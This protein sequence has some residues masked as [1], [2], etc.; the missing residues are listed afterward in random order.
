MTA[1]SIAE[2]LGGKRSGRDSYMVRCPAHEDRNPSLSIAGQDGKL[3]VKCF[4]GCSQR[5]VVDALRARGLW[6][7]VAAP[8][9]FQKPPKAQ[10]GPIIN[11]YL[12]T[13][14]HGVALFR[15]TRHSPKDFRQW[16][17]NGGGGWVLGIGDIRRVLYHLPEVI[18]AAI[19]FVVEGEKDV[20][21]LRDMGFAATC[22]PMGAGKWR[23]DFNPFFS[24]KDVV[25]IPDR[26]KPGLEHGWAVMAGVKPYAAHVVAVDLEDSKDVSEWFERGHSEVE[27][28]TLLESFWQG[29][30]NG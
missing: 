25:V 30:T 4:A 21:S 19:V 13:D 26:D 20:E 23:E 24:G 12:Y 14:E 1:A 8:A 2:A 9:P 15:V 17:P 6:P 22:C 16:R 3:L 29:V 10:L 7:D 28:I 27:L 11:E 18:E 5:A